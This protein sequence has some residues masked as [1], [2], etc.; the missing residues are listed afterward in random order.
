VYDN[1]SLLNL[2]SP[3]KELSFGKDLA[4]RF[5]LSKSPLGKGRYGTP[6]HHV[7]MLD[8]DP[9]KAEF[10]NLFSNKSNHMGNN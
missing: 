3:Q 1:S 5:P 10:S 2:L 4:C 8:D 6:Y 9:T 7:E